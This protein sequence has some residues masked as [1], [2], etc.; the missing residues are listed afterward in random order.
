MRRER[1]EVWQLKNNF[2][3]PTI[4]KFGA[5]YDHWSM[6]MENFLRSKEYWSLVETRI[7]TAAEGV[8]LTK[9][10]RKSIAD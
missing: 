6:L 1:I 4:P 9:A 2:A 7:P 3:Q 5:H 8:E 10:Q